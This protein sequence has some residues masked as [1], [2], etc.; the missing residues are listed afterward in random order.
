LSKIGGAIGDLAK[1]RMTDAN[2]QV[3]HW[4]AVARAAKDGYVA[5]IDERCALWERT[6][7]L[8]KNR[9]EASTFSIFGGRFDVGAARSSAFTRDCGFY[10][11]R[12]ALTSKRPQIFR[13]ARLDSGTRVVDL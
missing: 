5:A 10:A 8:R 9:T 13:I 1:S 11:L 3:E 2:R 12:R 7:R 4:I 6:C